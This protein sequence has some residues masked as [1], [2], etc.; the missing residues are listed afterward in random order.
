MN[1]DAVLPLLLMLTLLL[2]TLYSALLWMSFQPSVPVSRRFL[3]DVA[4]DAMTPPLSWVWL[5][6]VMSKPPLPANMPLWLMTLA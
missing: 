3:S 4:S 2:S 6:T 1:C 5:P